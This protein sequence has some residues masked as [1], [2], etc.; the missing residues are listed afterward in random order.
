[1]ITT[2]LIILIGIKLNMGI[3]FWTLVYIKGVIELA[4]IFGEVNEL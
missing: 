4:K 3:L 2:I 1:M